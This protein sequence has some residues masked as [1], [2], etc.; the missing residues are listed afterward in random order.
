MLIAERELDGRGRRLADGLMAELA[1][2]AGRTSAGGLLAVRADGDTVA[3]LHLW[4]RLTGHPVVEEH[5]DP[6]G[7]RLVLRI[8]EVE[9]M[10]EEEHER[11]LWI[12][13]NLHCNLACDYCCVRSSPQAD[14]LLMPLE[15]VEALASEAVDL[16]YER[17]LLTGGEPFLHPQL[18]ALVA[19]SAAHL[20]VTLLTNAMV[21]ATGRRREMLEALPRDRVTLQVSLDSP[22]PPLHDHHRG[23]GSWQRSREGIAIARDLGFRVR[24]AATCALQS[25]R[26]EMDA[27]LAAEGVPPEDRVIR[28]LASRG[29]AEELEGGV[30]FGRRDL[31]PEVTLSAAGAWWHPVGATDPDLQ[32]GPPGTSLKMAQDAIQQ[33]LDTWAE[34]GEHLMSVFHCS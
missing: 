13:T 26:D 23:E 22:T 31:V 27:F 7:A 19:A 15:R 28:P 5:A 29:E 17:I 25:E 32:L 2:A 30:A 8:G 12:Y 24:V 3:D 6:A 11:R 20:P 33:Q 4:S 14:P 9:G 16:G 18:D 34:Q 21:F 1:D 10:D